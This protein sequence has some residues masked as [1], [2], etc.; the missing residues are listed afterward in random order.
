MSLTYL[1]TPCAG[2][3]L[4]L[5]RTIISSDRI[6]ITDIG[7]GDDGALLC[8]TD[9]IQCCNSDS[10]RAEGQWLFPNGSSV[11]AGSAEV[12]GDFYFDRGPSVVRLH[13]RNNATS[14]TG[15][16]CCEVPDAT[17]TNMRACVN[18]MLEEGMCML[19]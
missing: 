9:L 18:I 3:Y 17:S 12:I 6:L 10:G 14:P 4:S 7:E 13:R 16:F 19:M 2:V 5:G 8:F 15:Q 1:L 11:L